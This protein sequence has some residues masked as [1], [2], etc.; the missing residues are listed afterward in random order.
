MHVLNPAPA[1][2]AAQARPTTPAP[3]TTASTSV[4]MRVGLAGCGC[5]DHLSGTPS[6]EALHDREPDPEPGKNEWRQHSAHRARMFPKQT[7]GTVMKRFER[8][9]SRV[10]AAAAA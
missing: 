9:V 6:N 7:I 10:A 5:D 1:S 3:M 2:S 8:R 4:R